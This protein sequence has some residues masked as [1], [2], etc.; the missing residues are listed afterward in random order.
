[1]TDT[2]REVKLNHAQA[3]YVAELFGVSRAIQTAVTEADASC[4]AAILAQSQREELLEVLG[5]QL[6]RM[7]FDERYDATD[8]G[9]LL[10]SIIDLLT[11]RPNQ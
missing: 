10:E 9:R 7:G 6:Q 5:A 11:S 8:E 2:A 3:R 4:T 1:M